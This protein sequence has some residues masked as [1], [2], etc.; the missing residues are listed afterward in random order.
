VVKILHLLR[1]AKSDWEDPK[2]P[3]ELRPLNGRGKRDA[4]RLARHLEL[5]PIDVQLVLCSPALRARRTLDAI[6]S[7]LPGAVSSKEPGIYAA[8]SD[9]L[10]ELIR[11]NPRGVRS[12]ML[13][14][15]NPGFEELTRRLLPAESVPEAFPTCA[16]ATFSF[17]T[18]D[19]AAIKPGS[20]RLEGFL[21]PDDLKD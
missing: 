1:H 13:V 18:D 5:H 21:T 2:L 19:W 14:G 8:A 15:H 11:R 6:I 20:G 3:D 12:L 7:S 10:L 9:Q 17:D 16:L 4:K